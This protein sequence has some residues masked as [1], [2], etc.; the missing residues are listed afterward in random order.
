MLDQF[1]NANDQLP[2][3]NAKVEVFRDF[4]QVVGNPSHPHY[5]CRYGV[6][7][8]TYNELGFVCDLNTTG[9]VTHWR[10]AE[11]VEPTRGDYAH[12]MERFGNCQ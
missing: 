10:Y 8:T 3:L 5:Q 12:I 4:G 1:H 11:T 9:R 6:E 7:V 2:T